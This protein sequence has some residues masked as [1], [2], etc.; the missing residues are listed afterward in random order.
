[1]VAQGAVHADEGRRQ[2]EDR[3]TLR[4][5]RLIPFRIRSG[6]G[7]GEEGR[8]KKRAGRSVPRRRRTVDAWGCGANRGHATH[9]GATGGRKYL[10]LLTI[11]R[12]LCSDVR[13]SENS[14]DCGN[15][16]AKDRYVD[17]C[18]IMT[19]GA[20]RRASSHAIGISVRERHGE[21]VISFLLDLIQ[22][23]ANHRRSAVL[24]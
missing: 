3:D 24:L 18:V 5:A 15:R 19:S 11:Y 22:V 9:W 14:P 17:V 12:F 10:S 7:S 16:P 21:A 1:M 2:R 13:W 8:N 6:R 20:R 23:P 4:A